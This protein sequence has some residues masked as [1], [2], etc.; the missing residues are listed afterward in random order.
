MLTEEQAK[1]KWCPFVNHH[2][3]LFQPCGNSMAGTFHNR[4]EEPFFY[5]IGSACMAW[6]ETLGCDPNDHSPL[7]SKIVVGGFCGLAGKP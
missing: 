1:T 2:N 7:G 5:C 6:R 3:A 4:G